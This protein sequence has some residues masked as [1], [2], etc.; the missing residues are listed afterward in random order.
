MA[1]FSGV[2]GRLKPGVSIAQAEAELTALYQR[3]QLPNETSPRPGEPPT[4][5]SD[6]RVGLAPGA[7]GLDNARQRLGQPLALALAVTGIVLMIA[8]VNVANLLLA[9]GAARTTELATRA[10]LGAGRA[11]LIRLLAIEGTMLAI[12][13]GLAGLLLAWL[14]TPALATVIH[15][16]EGWASISEWTRVSSVSGLRRP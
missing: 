15:L 7:Q 14:F 6:F 2:M 4:N 8:A 10:S 13:G 12:A 16:P 3:M 11:R 5:P 9:R 1:F